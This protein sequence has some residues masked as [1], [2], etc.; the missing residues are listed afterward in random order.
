VTG[1]HV[2]ILDG[3]DYFVS[4]KLEKQFQALRS[5]P[6]AR[7]VYGNLQLI[8]ADRTPLRLKWTRPMPSG[9]VFVP[10]A[11]AMFG[12]L[13]TLVVRYDLIRK[14]GFMDP[15]LPLYDGLWLTIQLAANCPFVYVDEVLVH[16]RDRAFSASKAGHG[17][18][19]VA[20]LR[21]IQTKLQPLMKD[22]VT[23]AEAGEI[24]RRWDEL[25]HKFASGES[26]S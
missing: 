20:D 2:G 10:V 21:L 7:A 16:K 6:D 23:D 13:R 26:G 15:E 22:R 9:D 19:S 1:T 11:S 17:P 4:D 18:R 12:V 8:D 3:D 25:I 24:N 14:V 5:R